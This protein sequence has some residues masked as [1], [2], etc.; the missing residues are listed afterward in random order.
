MKSKD[1]SDPVTPVIIEEE[2]VKAKGEKEDKDEE[3]LNQ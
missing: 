3:A 1:S 2:E